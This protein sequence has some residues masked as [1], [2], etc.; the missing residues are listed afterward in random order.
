MDEQ[1][2]ASAIGSLLV[3]SGALAVMLSSLFSRHGYGATTAGLLLGFLGLLIA[4]HIW[5]AVVVHALSVRVLSLSSLQ[6]LTSF[7]LDQDE[8]RNVGSQ[9]SFTRRLGIP[10]QRRSFRRESWPMK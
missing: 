1:E 9:Q 4:G 6:G 8:R 10:P 2:V 5:S 3:T 7:F